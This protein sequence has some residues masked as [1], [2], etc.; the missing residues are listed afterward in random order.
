MST[1]VV[2]PRMGETVDEG[3]VNTWHKAVGDPVAEGEPLVEIGTDKV[4]TVWLQR[5]VPFKEGEPYDPAKVEAMRGRLTS[6]GVFNAVRIKPTCGV[7]VGDGQNRTLT[8]LSLSPCPSGG[9]YP[10]ACAAVITFLCGQQDCSAS[11][12]PRW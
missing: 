11:R 4:D 2:M 3:T 9:W 12:C 10:H 5:R 1:D 8:L 6:L 7:P